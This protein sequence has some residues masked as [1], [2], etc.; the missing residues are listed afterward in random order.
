MDVS[1][2][3]VFEDYSA[4]TGQGVLDEQN[5]GREDGDIGSGLQ[6]G[7]DGTTRASPCH[8]TGPQSMA[9]GAHGASGWVSSGNQPDREHEGPGGASDCGIRSAE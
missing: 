7:E 4:S 9:H 2:G 6:D 8:W 1:A 3:F 5:D